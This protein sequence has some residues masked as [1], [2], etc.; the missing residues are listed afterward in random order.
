VEPPLATKALPSSS[1]RSPSSEYGDLEELLESRG[2]KKGLT[3]A[4]TLEINYEKGVYPYREKYPT[5]EYEQAKLLLQAELLKVQCWV[6]EAGQRVVALFEG[7]DAA[8][9]GG[10]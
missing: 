1:P 5:N 2:L 4:V 9:K 8:G 7:R 10:T 3:N 6:R